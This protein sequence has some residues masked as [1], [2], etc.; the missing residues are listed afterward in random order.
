M[1]KKKLSR[2]LPEQPRK[3]RPKYVM[4]PP[5]DD[6]DAYGWELRQVR[7]PSADDKHMA[8]RPAFNIG[9]NIESIKRYGVDMQFACPKYVQMMLDNT[10]GIENAV[11]KAKAAGWTPEALKKITDAVLKAFNERVLVDIAEQFYRIAPM[12][13]DFYAARQA[14]IDL[15]GKE[16][17]DEEPETEKPQIEAKTTKSRR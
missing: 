17:E 9:Q 16:Q 7:L 14:H 15:H 6:I 11:Q 2:A 3:K 1:A 12:V 10:P 4:P 13:A 8:S 5:N